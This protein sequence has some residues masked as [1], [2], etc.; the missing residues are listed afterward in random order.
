MSFFNRDLKKEHLLSIYLDE[1]YT[2]IGLSFKRISDLNLQLQ[3]IDLIYNHLGNDF[4]IDEK[5]QLDYINKDLPTFT[6]ELSYLKNNIKKI[7]WFLDDS[8]LTTHY[9]LITGIYANYKNDLSKG[10]NKCVITSVN[11]KKL[12]DYLAS[13]GLNHEKLIE[14]DKNI[15]A[16]NTEENK[17]YITELNNRNQG[18]LYYSPQLHEKPINLQLRLEFLI[19]ENIAKKIYP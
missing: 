17:T 2:K 16:S 6:F 13:I 14:Y 15:R 1:V 5:A 3:G 11:R 19:T 18:C 7:G 10:F 9:F 4:F 12:N 8:K